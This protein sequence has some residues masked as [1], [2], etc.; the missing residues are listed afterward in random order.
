M[1]S[2]PV[3]IPFRVTKLYHKCVE[4]NEHDSRLFDE[5]RKIKTNL[6]ASAIRWNCEGSEAPT[7]QQHGQTD[8]A[9]HGIGHEVP[10]EE[11]EKTQE[12]P[13]EE[14]KPNT[15]HPHEGARRCPGGRRLI[16]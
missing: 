8:N 10:E 3:V 15:G 14:G 12:T 11:E 13:T 5:F 1:V 6:R 9:E 16:S 7:R 2:A 4:E